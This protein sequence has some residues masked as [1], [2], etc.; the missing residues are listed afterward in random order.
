[1]PKTGRRIIQR[2][3]SH[4]GHAFL[5]KRQARVNDTEITVAGCTQHI[6]SQIPRCPLFLVP[7]G[8]HVRRVSHTNRLLTT[9]RQHCFGSQAG[10]AARCLR[11]G[12]SA[13]QTSTL[14]CV[15]RVRKRKARASVQQERDG[16][17]CM[18]EERVDGHV[19]PARERRM[20]V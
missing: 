12:R 16:R 5:A 7:S 1:M 15:V 18:S 6:D 13:V 9:D 3:G 10:D 20:S 19:P 8:V 4:A 17:S 14:V 11:G 2:A